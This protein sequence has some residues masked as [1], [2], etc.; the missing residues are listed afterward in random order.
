[1]SEF[2]VR[3]HDAFDSDTI[4][5]ATW[6]SINSARASAR[7]RQSKLHIKNIRKGEHYSVYEYGKKV[8]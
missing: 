2:E 4:V 7:I 1:M 8:Y 5:V 6:D 3:F